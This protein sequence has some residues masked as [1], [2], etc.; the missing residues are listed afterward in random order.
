MLEWLLANGWA[1]VG[2]TDVGFIFGTSKLFVS[3]FNGDGYWL[4]FRRDANG[5][6]DWE[7]AVDRGTG[8]KQLRAALALLNGSSPLPNRSSP[9]SPIRR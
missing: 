3:L 6:Y 8:L 4:L 5:S 7:D 1:E 2:A 9:A